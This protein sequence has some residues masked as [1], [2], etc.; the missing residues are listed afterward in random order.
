MLGHACLE[1]AA[2]DCRLL[3]DPWL[4]GSA[5][6]RSWWNYPPVPD[7]LLEG[8]DPNFIYLTHLHWD[9]FHG[10]TL[11]RL[12]LNRHILIPKTPDRRIYNDL[13]AMG[14]DHITELVHGKPFR[15]DDD[16]RITSY[17]FGHF[18]DSVLIIEANGKT[19]MNANDCK[20]MG[21][22][23]RQI[24]QKHPKIDFLLRS[25]SS[26]NA[27]LCFEIIDRGGQHTD[28][29]KKYSIEF[30][31]FA[32]AVKARYAIP[33][34]SN[35]CYLHPETQKFNQY[36]NFGINVKRYFE[37]NA[38][39]EPECVVCAPGDG[40]DHDAGFTLTNKDWYT[41]LDEHLDL[42]LRA[43]TATLESLTQQEAKVVLK[44]R[45]VAKYAESLFS[46]TPFPLRRLFRGKPIT[47]VAHSE[48]G[49]TAYEL[50]LYAK[51]WQRLDGWSDAENPIQI[52][53]QARIFLMCIKQVNWNSL[54]ISKRVRFRVKD[55][56]KK[57][58]SYFLEINDLFDCDVLP[59]SKCVNPRFALTWLRR[60][61]ELMLYGHIAIDL[62]RGRGFAYRN[63]LPAFQG[64]DAVRS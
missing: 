55:A 18:A 3:C 10:P 45:V 42:Y 2:S 11:R 37:Q 52:H 33:F 59:L 60:W 56:D 15:L 5:Y 62:A 48:A 16:F 46:G 12:G 14:C 7:G 63:Y 34:A 31:E 26:A 4:I 23:L 51:K 49:D 35:N 43:K 61:R 30:A 13:K 19:I 41:N 6:W 9:H 24:L 40:W 58:I 53:A 22:P 25:H 64:L 17:Q 36:L 28:D 47:L 44:E 39:V 57:Y 27:R 54:G 1:V 32:L 8:L 20:I 38:I 50:D 21:L 29:Q